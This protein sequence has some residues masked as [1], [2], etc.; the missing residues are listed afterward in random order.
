MIRILHSLIHNRIAD[1][2]TEA[3]IDSEM[4]FLA[5]AGRHFPCYF[6][7]CATTNWCSRASC[8]RTNGRFTFLFPSTLFV[9]MTWLI[10][11]FSLFITSLS[12]AEKKTN[13]KM[14]QIHEILEIH[15]FVVFDLIRKKQKTGHYQVLSLR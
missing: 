4:G 12:A 10:C 9:C 7:V 3:I 14:P 2:N 8:A 1:N 5:W 11:A 13:K 6:R 15:S